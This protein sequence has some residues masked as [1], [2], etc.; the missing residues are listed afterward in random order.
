MCL[1]RQ[2][3]CADRGGRRLYLTSLLEPYIEC[4]LW[5]HLYPT[6]SLCESH[7]AAPSAWQ[8][9]DGRRRD[10]AAERGSVKG[11]FIAKI[12]GPAADYAC[13]YDLLQFD[14]QIMRTIFGS[15]AA[16]IDLD[17]A[18]RRRHWSP[19]YWRR[20]HAY[21]QDLQR[22][23]GGFCQ[24][25]QQRFRECLQHFRHHRRCSICFLQ[26]LALPKLVGDSL[27]PPV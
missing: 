25:R 3:D 16:G 15:S 18:N 26:Q 13:R 19:Q 2:G 22:Q 12:C 4:A 14:R 5:P 6:K 1:D 20:Q 11:A 10:P 24:T 27:P 9:L 23:H 17:N 8:P 21:L 7:S